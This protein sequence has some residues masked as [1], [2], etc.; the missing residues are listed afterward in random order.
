[1]TEIGFCRH[2]WAWVGTKYDITMWALLLLVPVV[3]LSCG[4]GLFVV[5]VY[6]AW[7]AV[8]PKV[9]ARCGGKIEPYFVPYGP[10]GPCR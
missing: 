6:V 3:I 8:S 1:M 4:V 9:C 5:L 10:Q 7:K 2:C